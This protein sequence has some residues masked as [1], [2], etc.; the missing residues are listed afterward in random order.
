MRPCGTE[1]SQDAATAQPPNCTQPPHV[2]AHTTTHTLQLKH[3]HNLALRVALVVTRCEH[4]VY[5]QR[6]EPLRLRVVC[7]G[8]LAAVQDGQPP[9]L[10]VWPLEEHLALSYVT[11]HL[12]LCVWRLGCNRGGG[13]GRAVGMR[14]RE[15]GDGGGGERGTKARLYVLTGG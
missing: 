7:Q 2:Q 8:V 13:G 10:P 4:A 6:Y 1:H 11:L 15:R 5:R 3:S 9:A 14:K 12:R